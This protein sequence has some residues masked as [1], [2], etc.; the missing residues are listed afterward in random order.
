MLWRSSAK[1]KGAVAPT[2]VRALHPR[3]RSFQRLGSLAH[4]QGPRLAPVALP[5]RQGVQFAPS[6]RQETLKEVPSLPGPR[7]QGTPFF[8]CDTLPPGECVE[9]RLG[10]L[11]VRRVGGV[12]KRRRELGSQ[13]VD[14]HQA[15]RVRRRAARREEAA[16]Q[17]A[18][19]AK[20]RL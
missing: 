16:G 7:D 2:S 19:A 12:A 14:R 1:H 17:G 18:A 15:S 13:R 8:V 3:R 6:H 20:Q 5:T 11:D 9:R 10:A 4:V